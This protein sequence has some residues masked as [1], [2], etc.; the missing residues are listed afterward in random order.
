[1]AASG[2]LLVLCGYG[3]APDTASLGSD[4]P[5]AS[6]VVRG[7]AGVRFAN[8]GSRGCAGQSMGLDS[9]T[10]FGPVEAKGA[11]FLVCA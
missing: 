2:V 6:S 9:I 5:V 8:L 1:M 7:V 11:E 4:A 10:T 3:W